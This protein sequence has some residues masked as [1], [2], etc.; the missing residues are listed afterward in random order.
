MMQ[1][2]FVLAPQVRENR[3]GVGS[4]RA[5]IDIGGA[6]WRRSDIPNI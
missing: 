1:H 3:Q 6:W 5:V 4:S 2:T